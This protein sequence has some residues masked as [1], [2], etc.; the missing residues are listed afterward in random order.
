MVL[1][2]RGPM[3]AGMEEVYQVTSAL[4]YL[5]V[6]K[7]VALVTD[8]RF[9][10]VSTGAC[11]GHV[12]PEALAGGPIGKIRDGDRISVVIDRATLEGRVDLVD[13]PA[14]HSTRSWPAA[15]CATTCTPTPTCPPTRGCGPRCRTPAAEPGEGASTTSTR[16]F[17]DSGR[18]G[19]CRLRICSGSTSKACK[20]LTL[21]LTLPHS[22]PNVRAPPHQHDLA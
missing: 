17:R 5:D 16:L 21:S 15:P 2:C 7:Q 22:T 12:G 14:R 8:A 19:D 13:Q 3:G 20:V 6:G 11:I 9:S 4:K 10:G 1:I 18:L